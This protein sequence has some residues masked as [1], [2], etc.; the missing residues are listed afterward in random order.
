VAW[1]T[2]AELPRVELGDA[3]APVL[4]ALDADAGRFDKAAV[5]W[6]SCLCREAPLTL[7][8]A[9][10]SLSVLSA[11]AGPC[12]VAAGRALLGIVA[13]TASTTRRGP[14][15]RYSAVALNAAT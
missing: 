14:S 1:A 7:D 3:L 11:L 4:F 2:A 13:A 10:H 5:R 6:H 12:R 9:Q 15:S 8:E